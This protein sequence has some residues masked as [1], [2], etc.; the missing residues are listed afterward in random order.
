MKSRYSRTNQVNEGGNT[1]DPEDAII[2]R[3]SNIDPA[4]MGGV[5][6]RRCDDDYH[7]QHILTSIRFVV[8]SLAENEGRKALIKCALL[9]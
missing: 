3:N 9:C 1:P 2:C 8:L 6:Q 4:D 5:L 7:S